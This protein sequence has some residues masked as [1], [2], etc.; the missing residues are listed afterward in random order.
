MKIL[1]PTDETPP[2]TSIE[3]VRDVHGW[4]D[5]RLYGAARSLAKLRGIDSLAVSI[6]HEGD[7]A[8]AVVAA[9]LGSEQ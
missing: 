2:W 7:L 4:C 5:V 9:T 6:T 3:L 1:R 8:T